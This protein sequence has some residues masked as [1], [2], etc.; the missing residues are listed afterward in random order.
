[1]KCNADGLQS[2][3]GASSSRKGKGTRWMFYARVPDLPFK[4]KAALY[5]MRWC[6]TCLGLSTGVRQPRRG[7]G[8]ALSQAL[9]L[10]QLQELQ[11]ASRPTPSSSPTLRAAFPFAC[12]FCGL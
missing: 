6:K 11:T 7:G 12:I 9:A 1:M 4:W 10:P 2:D 8:A 5:L 3:E